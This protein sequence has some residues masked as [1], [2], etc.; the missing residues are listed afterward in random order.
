M[1]RRTQGFT[2][3]E[4]LVVIAIIAILAAILF[5]VFAQARA[6]ARQTT[7]LSNLKQIALACIMYASDND[8]HLPDGFVVQ[9]LVQPMSN[10]YTDGIVQ[11]YLWSITGYDPSVRAPYA[12]RGVINCPE[13]PYEEGLKAYKAWWDGYFGWSSD[14]T[15]WYIA[16][17][18]PFGYCISNCCDDLGHPYFPPYPQEQLP[19]RTQSGVPNPSMNPMLA[20]VHDTDWLGAFGIQT[21]SFIWQ[22]P[23]G[24]KVHAEYLGWLGLPAYCWNFLDTRHNNLANVAFID[25]HCKAM[26]RS[27]LAGDERYW[28]SD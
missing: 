21:G 18:T 10:I 15:K 2:L 6:K 4:L 17:R 1:N 19:G 26:N 9:P 12:Q 5:P 11:S 28:L 22:A 14:P 7:C 8:D 24:Y 16:N 13:L 25:G 23:P 3:I 27:T 20:D